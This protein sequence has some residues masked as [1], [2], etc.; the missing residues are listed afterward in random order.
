SHSKDRPVPLGR[1]QVDEEERAS[2][3]DVRN[4]NGPLEGRAT[5]EGLRRLRPERRPWVLTRSA[6]VGSQAT[7]ATWMGDN[8]SWWE[9]LEMSVPQL[10]SMGLSGSPHAGADIGGFRENASAEL[11][12]RWIELGAFYPFMRDHTEQGTR[13]Q[14][15]WAFGPAVE[16]V[17]RAAL[18]LR[19]RLLPYL[20]SLAHEATFSGAPLMRPL[21]FEFP[22]VAD[23]L[24]VD[25]AF[26]L[27]PWLLVAPVIRPRQR[28]RSVVLPPGRWRDFWSGLPVAAE[29]AARARPALLEAPL[30]R[31]PLLLREGAVLPLGNVRASTAA[32]LTELTL[33][34][35]PAADSRFE[36]VEDDGESVVDVGGLARTPLALS[37]QGGELTLSVGARSG[38]FVPPP[39]T[40]AVAL[41]LDAA[42]AAVT[43]DG[44]EVQAVWDGERRAATLSW[45]DDGAA[46]EVRATL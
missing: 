36:L 31:P 33:M 16:A 42:P 17:A 23:S 8:N 5:F 1:E 26:M 41:R 13:P 30:G 27:G 28:W 14:E 6:G 43:L 10:L 44:T 40:L 22:D 2:P 4:H 12:A 19:Y 46:H 25:S 9:H 45:R 15:P 34:A 18:E 11:F 24:D 29:A 35:S 3:Q 21:G 37:L 38:S 20:V 7:C 39:R 32:A